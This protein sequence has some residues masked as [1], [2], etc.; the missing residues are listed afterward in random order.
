VILAGM[1]IE[2]QQR[3]ERN[4][5]GTMKD[6]ILYAAIRWEFAARLGMGMFGRGRCFTINSKAGTQRVRSSRCAIAS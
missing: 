2:D 5:Q 3:K 6:A 1:R 4:L